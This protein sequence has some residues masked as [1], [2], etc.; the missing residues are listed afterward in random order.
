M[1]KNNNKTSF[2]LN[3]PI[4]VKQYDQSIRNF[5]ACY[6][7]I[8]LM[9]Y[10]FLKS[11]LNNNAKILIAGAGTGEEI[12]NFIKRNP[13]WELTGVDPSKDIL[14][15]AGNK[16]SKL[17]LNNS[18]INLINCYIDDLPEK[19]IYDAAT[20]ILVMHF[21]D[22][23]G[24][25]QNFINSISKRIKKNAQFILVDGFGEKN[26]YNFNNTI[27][28]WKEFAVSMGVAKDIVESGF[29]NQILKLIK[30]V[31]ENRIT[32]LLKNA[33]FHKISKFFTGFLYGGW[34]AE[35]K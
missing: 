27:N 35:K 13:Q 11:K 10:S 22:D 29:N 3:P 23:N 6:E 4:D 16:L 9:S 24:E 12:C 15:I 26:T 7:H 25:K 20:S 34:I 5:C 28:A 21:L 30:F 18:K 8:L 33:G 14:E 32:E 19:Q 1:I 31:P 17:N 2:D